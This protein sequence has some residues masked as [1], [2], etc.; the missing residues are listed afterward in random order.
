M[1]HRLLG[2][3]FV[4]LMFALVPDNVYSQ[5]EQHSDYQG[6][7]IKSGGN[8]FSFRNDGNFQIFQRS[9]NIGFYTD[10]AGTMGT[11]LYTSSGRFDQYSNSYRGWSGSGYTPYV[12]PSGSTYERMYEND[13]LTQSRYK[14]ERD[15]EDVVAYPLLEG[16]SI[17]DYSKTGYRL[18]FKNGRIFA[19][20]TL[21]GTSIRDYLL[22]PIELSAPAYSQNDKERMYFRRP[23]GGLPARE[24]LQS[25]NSAPSSSSIGFYD[26][27]ERKKKS[28]DIKRLGYNYPASK[29]TWAELFDIEQRILKSQAIAKL[30]VKKDWQQHTWTVLHDYEQRIMKSNDISRLGVN[31]SWEDYS[32]NA[33]NDAELR[34]RKCGEL[35]AMGKKVNWQDY[36]YLTLS[37]MCQ[38]A[39]SSKPVSKS[40]DRAAKVNGT[41]P[42][43]KWSNESYNS[44]L[45]QV[46][47]D[48]WQEFDKV[49][50]KVLWHYREL[51]RN[52]EYLEL[53]LTERDQKIRFYPHKAELLKDGKW[54]WVSNGKWQ[55]ADM[56]SQLGDHDASS[57][58]AP[59]SKVGANQSN[60]GDPRKSWRNDSYSSQIKWVGNDKWEE[61]DNVTEQLRWHYREVARKDEY[62]ELLLI[63]RNQKIRFYRDKAE[64]LKDG[65]WEWL[66]N[67]AWQP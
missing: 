53:L 66:S 10:S 13:P 54:E 61:I 34:I 67:G 37:D 1:C 20:P 45:E 22:E 43:E 11:S 5:V 28:D 52:S 18:V 63:E 35:S 9:G 39:R 44:Q 12:A 32:W 2:S 29:H 59:K 57:S 3:V 16:T 17:R 48:S 40:E 60:D 46:G 19:Y 38:K 8:T 24:S 25:R 41:D 36:D 31:L 30:G 14:F 27:N 21:L 15:G 49:T 4:C 65:K 51:S 42:R 47:K 50:G 55:A 23:Y 58:P 62:L 64:L 26:M 33:L 7:S 6:F 56:A